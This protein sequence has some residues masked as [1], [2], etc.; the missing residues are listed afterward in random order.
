MVGGFD[1]RF[2]LEQISMALAQLIVNKVWGIAAN[3]GYSNVFVNEIGGSIVDDHFYVNQG[4]IP[5]ID[6]IESS[7]PQTGGFNPTWHTHADNMNNISR[8]SLKAVGQVLLN[9]IYNEQ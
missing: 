5:C 1:A 3:S 7:N 8:T 2:S 9:V 6:I 4:G